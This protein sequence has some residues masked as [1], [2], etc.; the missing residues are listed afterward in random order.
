M[1]KDLHV[2]KRL[3]EQHARELFSYGMAFGVDKEE[4]EDAI[5][6]V[7]LHLIERERGARE[8]DDGKFYLL[9]CLKNRLL[10]MKRKKRHDG[11]LDEVDEAGFA[12]R[13]DGF[14]VIADEEERRAVARLVEEMLLELTDR[15]R[16]AIYL[17]YTCELGFEEIAALLDI[18]PKSARKLV[19]RAVDLLRGRHLPLALLYILSH[20][21]ARGMERVP[22]PSW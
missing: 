2:Y 14:E 5:H 6:D 1:N 19:Y 12:V 16:E 7:F 9:A 10:S 3:Y 13:V 8:G 11:T 15:Q 4:L 21:T 20:L 18:R 17:R 22:P